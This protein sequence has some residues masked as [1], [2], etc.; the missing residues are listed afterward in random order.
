MNY[1][2]VCIEYP[3]TGNGRH[4]LFSLDELQRRTELYVHELQPRPN[5]PVFLYGVSGG[6]NAA[7]YMAAKLGTRC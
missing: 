6:A 1:F 4:L 5:Q 2:V 7:V 3:G